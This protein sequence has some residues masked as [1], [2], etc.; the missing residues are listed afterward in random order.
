MNSP[1]FKCYYLLGFCKSSNN[2]AVN[3]DQKNR[4]VQDRNV[5]K[6]VFIC[7]YCTKKKPPALNIVKYP[8]KL[9]TRVPQEATHLSGHRK[10][11]I[12]QR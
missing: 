6:E 2:L 10:R 3:I 9:L 7:P 4:D 5:C 12:V 8:V 11:Y 1:F